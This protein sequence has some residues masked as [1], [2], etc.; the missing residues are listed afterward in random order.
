MSR[1]LPQNMQQLLHKTFC[2]ARHS[3][4]TAVKWRQNT[5]R[6][7]RSGKLWS[8]SASTKQKSRQRIKIAGGY[9]ADGSKTG[10]LTDLRYNLE[11]IL[12]LEHFSDAL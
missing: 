12:K 1:T 6:F 3:E 4:G 8:R 11:H 7:L 5:K 9:G 10:N 2:S